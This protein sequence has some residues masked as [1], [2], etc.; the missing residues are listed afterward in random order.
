[1][2]TFPPHEKHEAIQA[3]TRRLHLLPYW[4]S[5]DWALEAAEAARVAEFCEFYVSA[6]PTLSVDEKFALM[7][8][9]V[10]SLD[11][12]LVQTLPEER[13]PALCTQVERLLRR[14]YALHAPI[15]ESWCHDAASGSDGT[16]AEV[17]PST[18]PSDENT[19]GIEDAGWTFYVT[20]LMRRIRSRCCRPATRT[21]NS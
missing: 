5:D 9:I 10:A 13:D 14:D 1:V 16:E 17:N 8:L 3:L 6:V 19:D 2:A 20:P 18:F 7:S 12:Y 11:D 21:K 4:N 15:V